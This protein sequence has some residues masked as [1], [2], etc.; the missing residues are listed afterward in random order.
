MNRLGRATI[1]MMLG[2]AG[3][4]L[5]GPAAAAHA[6][7]PDKATASR[8]SGVQIEDKERLVL[9]VSYGEPVVVSKGT[10]PD[11]A[12]LPALDSRV[13]TVESA[14]VGRKFEAAPGT[15]V[16]SFRNLGAKGAVLEIENGLD[17]PILYDAEIV[18]NGPDGPRYSSTTICPVLAGR[19]G[20]ESWPGRV[21]GVVIS[22]VRTPPP[23][24]MRCTGGKGLVNEQ[25]LSP[26]NQCTSGKL[27]DAVRVDLS[28]D[29]VTGERRGALAAWTLGDLASGP[30]LVFLFPMQGE[31][32]AGR[33][34][35]LQVMAI[36][37]AQPPPAA[38]Q[39]EIVLLADGREAARRPWKLYAQQR[40]A[41][42]AAPAGGKPVAFVGIVPFPLRTETGEIQPE[43]AALFAAV[44]D[45]RVKSIEVRVVGNDG[46]VLG[47]AVRVLEPAAI[48]DPVQVGA[49]LRAA[50]AMAAAPGHCAKA[51]PPG[52]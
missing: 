38:T 44:G 1:W 15:L 8:P 45:G 29:P 22:N 3:L 20:I 34:T 49:A 26:A 51:G 10:A 16:A 24:D 21:R 52:R 50:E 17:H 5:A 40:A 33:P 23:G 2:L 31:L 46:S 25:G 14:H 43:M 28:V 37:S 19:I 27:G 12:Y 7:T 41:L 18:E 42:G 35:G 13:E 39:A 47:R 6:D 36:V 32:V 30:S 48:R 11:D 4:A 9:S